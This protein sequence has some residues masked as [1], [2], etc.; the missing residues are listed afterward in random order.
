[1]ILLNGSEAESREAIEDF[2]RRTGALW[3]GE[4]L[5][6]ENE[7]RFVRV[8]SHK[9]FKDSYINVGEIKWHDD[10]CLRNHEL[11]ENRVMLR[12]MR[13]GMEGKVGTTEI[14]SANN[15]I[16]FNTN[17]ELDFILK[18]D[19]R[20][21]WVAVSFPN[22]VFH[23]IT[24]ENDFM[25]KNLIDNSEPWF[26][27]FAFTPQIEHHVRSMFEIRHNKTLSRSVFLAKIIE[28]LGLL[29]EQFETINF[30]V[31]T[32]KTSVEIEKMIAIKNELISDFNKTPNVKELASKS[33]MSE[34]TLQRSFKELFHQPIL[35]F[36]NQNR[37]EEAHRQIKYTERSVTEISY[38]LG[39]SHVHH[40][41]NS[42]KKHFGYAPNSLRTK[43]KINPVL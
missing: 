24:D 38:R 12:V 23:G 32:N 34:S 6:F 30:G 20:T 5:F 42:F 15:I 25:L 3:D 8:I 7:D 9:Y 19:I 16:M 10:I 36:F 37:L 28:I 40:L 11:T 18:K 2:S 17:Q 26:S 27:Y 43:K 13:T 31:A 22:E 4:E 21:K 39:Y 1:M 41:S 33:N 29:R 14:A 35:K